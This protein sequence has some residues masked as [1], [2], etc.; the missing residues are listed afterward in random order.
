MSWEIIRWRD[1]R[2][3][4]WYRGPNGRWRCRDMNGVPLPEEGEYESLTSVMDRVGTLQ[5]VA[6]DNQEALLS[7]Y[8]HV[9][10]QNATQR[11]EVEDLKRERDS[12]SRVV[13]MLAELVRREV[14]VH[15]V[16]P[17]GALLIG[18][19]EWLDEY[20]HEETRDLLSRLPKL[21]GCSVVVFPGEIKVRAQAPDV[22][23]FPR[24]VLMGEIVRS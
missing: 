18:N 2:N 3:R 8:L 22:A 6:V 7:R 12:L 5:P 16:E 20:D 15:R 14:V 23:Q 11:A 13:A 17:G 9:A 1:V 24:R 21:L 10:A 19:V 4:T